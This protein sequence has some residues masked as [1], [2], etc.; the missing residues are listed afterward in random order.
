MKIQIKINLRKLLSFIRM[1][2]PVSNRKLIKLINKY[3]KNFNIINNTLNEMAIMMKTHVEAEHEFEGLI[4]TEIFNIIKMINS[5]KTDQMK[6][7]DSKN[8][9]NG[10]KGIMYG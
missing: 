9:K 3:N 4:R 10:N 6:K 7:P 1:F 8:K 2:M 5:M